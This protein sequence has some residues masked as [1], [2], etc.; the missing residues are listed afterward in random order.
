MGSVMEPVHTNSYM[1]PWGSMA[2]CGTFIDSGVSVISVKCSNLAISNAYTTRV[3]EEF[4][5]RGFNAVLGF[6][7][8]GFLV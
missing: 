5:P 6:A 1:A 3:L 8:L 2:N 7:L 4:I